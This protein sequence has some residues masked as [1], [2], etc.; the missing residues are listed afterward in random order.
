[1]NNDFPLSGKTERGLFQLKTFAKLNLSL[2]V[3][4]KR[5]DGYHN[6]CSI[7][8]TISLHDNLS[9][10]ITDN[11]NFELLTNSENLGDI[12]TNILYKVFMRFQ[13]DISFGIKMTL[14]KQIPIGGGLGGGSSNAAGFL[15]FLNQACGWNYSLTKLQSISSQFGA[16]V[17]FFIRGGTS[18]VRGVGD[19]IRALSNTP[20]HAYIL[21][22]PN[23]ACHTGAIYKEYDVT[24]K[25]KI[26]GR[27]P[28]S[29]L[30]EF[31][32]PN[33]LKSVAFSMHPILQEIEGRLHDIGIDDVRMSGSGSTL[34]IPFHS[35]ALA[36]KKLEE[37]QQILSFSKVLLV[38]P[39][40]NG[41]SLIFRS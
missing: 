8:Q 6:I 27:T 23:V 11:N 26:L 33:D 18:L 40:S 15:A 20:K 9:I 30:T 34:F 39:V 28:Q 5:P 25:H 7:F 29:L 22:Q 13:D 1:L 41:F 12:S 37:V 10:E 2:L 31:L 19:K 16:D 38:E 3:S 17:P 14:D 24:V 32:G 4:S 36:K 21:I 35:T